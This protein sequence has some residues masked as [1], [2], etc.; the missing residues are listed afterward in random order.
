[1]SITEALAYH[2][3]SCQSHGGTITL[4]WEGRVYAITAERVRDI[5][6]EAPGMPG[7]ED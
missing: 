2:Q 1:M 6:I 7:M 5:T 3:R 4:S